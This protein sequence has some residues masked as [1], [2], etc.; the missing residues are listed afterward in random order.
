M[1]DKYNCI[2]TYEDPI[3]SYLLG[4]IERNIKE[5]ISFNVVDFVLNPEHEESDYLSCDSDFYIVAIRE[6]GAA[7]HYG[8]RLVQNILRKRKDSKVIVY[9]Q[10]S[11]IDTKFTGIGSENVI[12]VIHD[13]KSLVKLLG[14]TFKTEKKYS[15]ETCSIS[16]PYYKSSIVNEDKKRL[17][18]AAIETTRGC[19]FN[20]DFCFINNSNVYEKKWMVRNNDQIVHDIDTYYNDGIRKF[21]F[22]DLEFLGPSKRHHREKIEL[23]K[24]ISKRF[25]DIKYMIYSRADTLIKFNQFD[26]LKDSG[27]YN[28]YL[29]AESFFEEDLIALKKDIKPL[30]I[31]RCVTKLLDLNIGVFLSMIPFNRNSTTVSIRHNVDTIAKLLKHKFAASLR[32]QTFLVNAEHSWGNKGLEKYKFSDKTYTNWTMYM[33]AHTSPKFAFDSN[34]EPLIELFRT[35]A[36]ENEK[37]S[38][39]LNLT[40]QKLKDEDKKKVEVWFANIDKFSVFCASYFLEQFE[41]GNLFLSEGSIRN[42]QIDL[43]KMVYS[44]NCKVLPMHLSECCT[45]SETISDVDCEP[46]K[47]GDH[48]FDIAIPPINEVIQRFKKL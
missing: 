46:I 42:N 4:F 36:Y 11:T 21:L 5:N 7:P 12:T 26:L 37:K 2:A 34:L 24:T 10:V 41:K 14:L 17:F 23:L 43:F 25:P 39:E 45:K 32:I 29:G 28:V 48:G 18:V 9:G 6:K 1:A 8:M 40:Y 44:F 19:L 33:Q 15:Y 20:C 16:L 31:S 13:E 47:L 38:T 22:F 30:E 3:I 35:L 27:L